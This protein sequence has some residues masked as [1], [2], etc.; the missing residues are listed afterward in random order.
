MGMWMWMPTAMMC[1]CEVL[2]C[3]VLC[4]MDGGLCALFIML[5]L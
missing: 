5:S 4:R 2:N 1:R 3:S